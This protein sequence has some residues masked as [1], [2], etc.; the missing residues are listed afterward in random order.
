MKII[1]FAILLLLPCICQSQDLI[2]MRNGERINCKITNVDDNAIHYDFIKE[3]R[4]L[5]SYVILDKVNSYVYDSM[6][7]EHYDIVSVNTEDYIKIKRYWANLITVSQTFG[8]KK[9]SQAI[10]YFGYYFTSDSKWL[11]PIHLGFE[12]LNFN[13]DYTPEYEPLELFYSSIGVSPLLILT[14]NF[15]L[16]FDCYFLYGHEKY[17]FTPTENRSQTI[18]GVKMSQCLFFIPE[19]KFG[20]TAGIGIYQNFLESDLLRRDYGVN[21]EIGLK[22]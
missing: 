20:I 1:L 10:H 18:W 16:K 21:F 5:S 7:G 11:F 14:N 22:F 4:K 6:A 3:D 17:I 12:S 19:S 9:S 8:S 13:S 15:Y 2:I